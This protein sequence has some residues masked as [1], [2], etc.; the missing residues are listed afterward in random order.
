MSNVVQ[1][2]DK[3][4]WRLTVTGAAVLTVAVHSSFFL[5]FDY[6]KPTPLTPKSKPY[7]TMMLNLHTPQRLSMRAVGQWLEYQTPAIMS[8]PDYRFGY[9]I[10]GALPLWREQLELPKI[11]APELADK[12]IIPK[13]ENLKAERFS[14]PISSL[15]ELEG[16]S[17]AEPNSLHI[18]RPKIAPLKYPLAMVSGA[19]LSA[20]DLSAV[21]LPEDFNNITS[22]RLS[23]LPGQLTMVPRVIVNASCGD[24]GLDQAGVRV[25]L[26][27]ALKNP[28]ELLDGRE[29]EILWHPEGVK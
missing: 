28:Q 16:L 12:F 5:L 7:K 17:S 21:K 25:L 1:K 18:I 10:A 4:N 24:T 26:D 14:S 6:K 8:R 23:I 11:A 19:P 22:T 20:I 9:S 2:N 3:R 27:Y 13:F 29:I 15:A